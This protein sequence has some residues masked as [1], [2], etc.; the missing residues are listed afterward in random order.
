MAAF[1]FRK[2]GNSSYSA[3]STLVAHCSPHPFCS[4]QPLP[5]PTSLTSRQS[6][7]SNLSFWPLPPCDSCTK[8]PELARS[9]C[10]QAAS[11]V[12]T[13]KNVY[14]RLPL[15]RLLDPA[16]VSQAKSGY[17]RRWGNESSVPSSITCTTDLGFRLLL[18]SWRQHILPLFF[19]LLITYWF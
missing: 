8:T 10:R 16:L 18:D 17:I 2:H 9:G 3:S 12:A 1:W 13:L 11:L 15:S 14:T 7:Y 4:T 6:A 19:S 5:I